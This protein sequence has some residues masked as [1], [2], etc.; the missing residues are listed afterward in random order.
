MYIINKNKNNLKADLL[1]LL[2]KI[3]RKM[4]FV[5]YELQY[6]KMID[7]KYDDKN[8]NEVGWKLKR[9]VTIKSISDV[10]INKSGSKRKFEKIQIYKDNMFLK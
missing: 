3:Q 2:Y 9:K 1:L 4:Y 7:K 5:I 10:V 6:K 8:V